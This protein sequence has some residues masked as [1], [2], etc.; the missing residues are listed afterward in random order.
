MESWAHLLLHFYVDRPNLDP[1]CCIT[2]PNTRGRIQ[3][4]YVL[5]SSVCV[6]V[7]HNHYIL[8]VSYELLISYK[9]AKKHTGFGETYSIHGPIKLCTYDKWSWRQLPPVDQANLRNMLTLETLTTA[10][11]HRTHVSIWHLMKGCCAERYIAVV[12]RSPGGQFPH[13]FTPPSLTSRHSGKYSA[14]INACYIL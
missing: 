11:T 2:Q 8:I 7:S 12:C 10:C 9:R 13:Y 6:T 5:A 3:G 1:W 4:R 14:W